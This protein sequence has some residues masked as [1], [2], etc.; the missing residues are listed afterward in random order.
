M[1]VEIRFKHV[2][3]SRIE[4]EEPIYSCPITEKRSHSSVFPLKPLGRHSTYDLIFGNLGLSTC[5]S[6]VDSSYYAKTKKL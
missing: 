1:V 6:A 5:W 3:N 2:R 4:G